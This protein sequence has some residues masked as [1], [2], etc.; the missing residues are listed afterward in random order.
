MTPEK[1]ASWMIKT[2]NI[3]SLEDISVAQ[4]VGNTVVIH[5]A[6]LP[7]AID[8]KVYTSIISQLTQEA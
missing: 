2:Y 5:L 6:G 3:Q 7:I 8:R 4:S 1:L